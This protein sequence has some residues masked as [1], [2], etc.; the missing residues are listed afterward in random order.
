MSALRDTNLPLEVSGRFARWSIVDRFIA[1]VWAWAAERQ[2]IAGIKNHPLR[3]PHIL[4]DIG[5]IDVDMP[6]EADIDPIRPL[7]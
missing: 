4:R 2:H 5:L 7:L 1:H 3:D 6:P